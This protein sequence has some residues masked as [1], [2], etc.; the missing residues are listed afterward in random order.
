MRSESFT[1]V[2]NL[3]LA[4]V[5]HEEGW[6]VLFGPLITSPETEMIGSGQGQIKTHELHEICL[7]FMR[8]TLNK[9]LALF[10]NKYLE[11]I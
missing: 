9:K 11:R 8:D 2:G 10:L 3:P 1:F 5:D 4:N 6:G 7:N